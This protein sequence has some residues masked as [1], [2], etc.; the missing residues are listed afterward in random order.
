MST[1][2]ERD[3]HRCAFIRT[4]Q[5]EVDAQDPARHGLVSDDVGEAGGVPESAEERMLRENERLRA[6][7]A[8]RPRCGLREWC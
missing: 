5:D 4:P 7:V 8:G 3:A 1:P 2:V 6:L